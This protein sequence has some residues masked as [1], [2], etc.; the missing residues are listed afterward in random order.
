MQGIKV[1]ENTKF[2]KVSEVDGG[3]KNEV[4]AV[5]LKMHWHPFVFLAEA[6]T[7]EMPKQNVT[8]L[9]NEIIKMKDRQGIS[10]TCKKTLEG[11][12]KN[13]I[14]LI[15]KN[16]ETDFQDSV[17][18]PDAS[19]TDLS[20]LMDEKI[21]TLSKFSLDELRSLKYEW[22]YESNIFGMPD[23]IVN[24][25]SYLFVSFL[26]EEL[27]IKMISGIIIYLEMQAYYDFYS[28]IRING[29]YEHYDIYF[30]L[31]KIAIVLFINL[32]TQKR[33]DINA[34]FD[35]IS[36]NTNEFLSISNSHSYNDNSILGLN[37]TGVEHNYFD[38]L[39]RNFSR[40]TVCNM[41]LQNFCYISNAILRN[42]LICKNNL[43]KRYVYMT[44]NNLAL[45]EQNEIYPIFVEFVGNKLRELSNLN[46][47]MP[48]NYLREV[49]ENP[50][51]V[52][53]KVIFLPL[54]KKAKMKTGYELRKDECTKIFL[55]LL[56][57]KNPNEQN[58]QLENSTNEEIQNNSNQHLGNND[59][60]EVNQSVLSS[61]DDQEMPQVNVIE[62]NEV[63]PMEEPKCNC[64]VIC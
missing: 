24:E 42:G 27:I 26:S 53:E 30:P 38:N 6:I 61:R 59:N 52:S 58:Q 40:D 33:M 46:E 2:V 20:N 45:F 16:R 56:K 4:E 43:E 32:L 34:L 11:L 13:I 14:G 3:T 15:D 49:L 37:M 64:C 19:D 62:Q 44:A 9:S 17:D 54:E 41:F 8:F 25:M 23:E 31:Y 1:F 39:L 21:S 12:L 63:P 57:I 48:P 35:D 55:Y 36:K 22:S 7:L 10:E 47:Q 29:P 28:A 60:E 50:E 18:Y 51:E 5:E